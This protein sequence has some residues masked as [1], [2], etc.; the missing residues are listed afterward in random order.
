MWAAPPTVVDA[1]TKITTGTPV[2]INADIWG[3]VSRNRLYWIAGDG[4]ALTRKTC[5][6]I[7]LP[8]GFELTE[9]RDTGRF[10]VTRSDRKPWPSRILFEDGYIPAISPGEPGRRFHVLT[11]EFST[12]RTVSHS[13]PQRLRSASSRTIAASLQA[14]MRGSPWFGNRTSGASS[15]HLSEHRCTAFRQA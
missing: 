13:P 1:Y 3:W 15:R 9:F 5:T 8:D 10:E 12:L 6:D 14:H 2:K 7:K 11:R 4:K